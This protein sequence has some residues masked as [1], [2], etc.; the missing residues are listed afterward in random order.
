MMGIYPDCPATP[1]YVITTPIFDKVS[2][3]TEQGTTTILTHRPDSN[4]HYIDHIEL[5]GKNIGYFI[6][7]QELM[8]GT[9]E[10]TT[11]NNYSKE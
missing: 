5:N 8:G 4:S 2:I 10:V 1:R 6:S 3:H 7:H 9:I 11:K